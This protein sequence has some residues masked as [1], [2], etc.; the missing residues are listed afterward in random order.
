MDL[1][2]A[3]SAHEA[4]HVR[5]GPQNFVRVRFV[6]SARTRTASGRA[7]RTK[8][9]TP[10]SIIER[11]RR[12]AAHSTGPRTEAGKARSRWNALKHGL[13]CREILIPG[14]DGKESRYRL[15]RLIAALRDELNPQGIL[16]EMMVEKIAGCY[17]RLRRVM[18][19]E[20][21][22]IKKRLNFSASRASARTRDAL[23]PLQDAMQDLNLLDELRECVERD[24]GLRPADSERIRA[25]RLMA[26]SPIVID[27]LNRLLSPDDLPVQEAGAANSPDGEKPDDAEAVARR[28]E[29]L[30]RLIDSRRR[31]QRTVIEDETERGADQYAAHL[32]AALSRYHLP[33]R[34]ASMRLRLYETAISRELYRAMREL[35]QLQLERSR[36][37]GRATIALE[38]EKK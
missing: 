18:R 10:Q 35:K 7:R 21:G 17:W 31:I 20:V 6:M 16:E 33:D 8:R 13:L 11:N 15:Q 9:P 19:A 36:R 25:F 30:L 12:N 27:V 2:V 4:A 38:R 32:D 3:V 26:H 29:Q 28:R 34:S 5:S 37:G 14:G 24:G 22:E 1:P 23:Q